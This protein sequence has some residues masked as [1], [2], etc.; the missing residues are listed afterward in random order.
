MKV[1]DIAIIIVH[2]KNVKDTLETL[3][4]LYKATLPQGVKMTPYVVN[5]DQSEEIK[6]KIPKQFPKAVNIF[7]STNLGFSGGN[8][9]GLKTALKGKH[10][11]FVLLNN[12]VFVKKDFI[13]KIASSSITKADVGIVGGLIYFAP[14]FEFKDKYTKKEKGK[15]IWYAGGTIDWSNVFAGH[16]DVDKVDTGLY[17]KP[18]PTDF[19][20]GCLLIT[21]REILEE[22]GLL[23][24]KFCLYLEDVDFNIR[25][26]QA[27]YKTIFDPEIQIW[28]K[29]AQSSGIGSP[30]NDYFLTRNRLLLGFKYT[31][32]RT[33]FALV[34]EAIKKLFTGTRAQR[35]AIKDF[36]TG[37]L[38]KGS[39]LK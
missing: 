30:L 11:T 17:K 20:T 22:L 24:D 7:S 39:W 12:D 32:F 10:D 25:V 4:S 33:K 34:R 14:G 8:N 26:Q 13:K 21:K 15:V 29:V 6:I 19:I 1:K 37:N 18:T 3:D 35:I 16:I 28:H 27:G 5:N 38:G 31:P 2:F 36:F 23:D 9:L